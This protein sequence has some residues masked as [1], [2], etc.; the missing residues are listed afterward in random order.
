M[1]QWFR[2]GGPMSSAHPLPR[3]DAVRDLPA[4][5]AELDE[6][7]RALH[8]LLLRRALVVEQ[9][10]GLGVK[11][12]VPLRPGREAAIVRGLLS[13]HS[14]RFPAASLVR[15]WRELICGMTAIQG[16]LR[17]A[18]CEAGGGEA[19]LV[20]AAREHFGALIPL[21]SYA[22][23][24]QAIREVSAGLAVAAVLPLPE[25]EEAPRA[26]WWTA[27]LQEDEP[28]IH[29][30]ARLPF[31]SERP[32]GTP[33]AQGFVVTAAA[34][35]PSGE[36]RALLGM[37]LPYDSSRARLGAELAEAGFAVGQIIVRR[38]AGAGAAQVLV[39]V[40]GFLDDGD[41]RLAAMAKRRPVVLGCYAVPV[42]WG[43]R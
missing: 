10:G 20:A 43:P 1:G 6:M 13:R 5:R 26:A 28:R 15:V 4:L 39:D 36:D 40:E 8:A 27:L 14:G 9:V 22:T 18:V 17:I 2:Y 33:A 41:A 35:D 7:D 19:G 11:G 31:W 16:R 32:E 29:V 24:A 25:E 38:E 3:A 23:A 37:E 34:P 42:G 30:V 21:Q 12:R